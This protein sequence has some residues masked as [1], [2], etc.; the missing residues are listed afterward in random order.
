MLGSRLLGS[1]PPVTQ[2]QNGST[3]KAW[4]SVLFLLNLS[5]SMVLTSP[6]SPPQPLPN[7][8]EDAV[9]MIIL[10]WSEILQSHRVEYF[11]SCFLSPSLSLLKWPKEVNKIRKLSSEKWTC[12]P[13]D[14][15]Q[16]FPVCVCAG[17]L[18]PSANTLNLKSSFW[19]VVSL[20]EVIP[21]QYLMPPVCQVLWEHSVWHWRAD[22][23]ERLENTLPSGENISIWESAFTYDW[24]LG[25]FGVWSRKSGLI[26]ELCF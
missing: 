26:S 15:G 21:Q 5:G 1:P 6:P 11:V 24:L 4:F 2:Q 22:S 19:R 16:G 23:L 7:T 12:G 13:D 25:N 18:F 14:L 3:V 10:Y 20:G 9:S 8:T 17:L